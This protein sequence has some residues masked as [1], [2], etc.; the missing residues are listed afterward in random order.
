MKAN[1]WRSL[2]LGKSVPFGSWFVEFPKMELLTP[3]STKPPDN[4]SAFTFWEMTLRAMRARVVVLTV[5]PVTCPVNV[6]LSK[7]T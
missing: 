5:M 2:Y 3:V 7:F 6:Q 1:A 4:P